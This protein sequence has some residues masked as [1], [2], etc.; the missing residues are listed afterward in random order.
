MFYIPAT[1][2]YIEILKA[3]VEQVF[4]QIPL[5]K[6]PSLTVPDTVLQDGTGH[7]FVVTLPTD[8]TVN[9]LSLLLLRG[10]RSVDFYKRQQT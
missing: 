5:E 2:F 1:L 9:L 10:P 8:V 4:F 3:F 7:G 6:K